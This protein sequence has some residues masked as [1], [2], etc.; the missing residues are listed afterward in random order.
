MKAILAEASRVPFAK[1][2]EDLVMSTPVSDIHTHLYDPAFGELL[3]WGI[4]DLLVYHYLVAEGFR[5]FDLPYEKFWAL[6]KT[7]QADLIWQALFLDHSPVS[8]ACRGVL[9]TLHA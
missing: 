9:T 2:I 3:L 4:D 6:S 5:Y 1:Q 8:E 7:A